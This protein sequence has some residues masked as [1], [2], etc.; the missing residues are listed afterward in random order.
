[1]RR[2]C[3]VFLPW[4]LLVAC[5]EFDTLS[6]GKIAPYNAR[7]ITLAPEKYNQGWEFFRSDTALQLEQARQSDHWQPVSLPHTV[8]IEPRVVNNQWQGDAWYRKTIKADPRWKGKK[9]FL[10]FEGAMNFSEVWLNGVKVAEHLGGYSPFSV[11]IGEDLKHDNNQLYVRLDN[12]DNPLSGPKPLTQLD[13]NMYGGI[14]RN[15]WLR[16][17]NPLHI[18]HPVAAN[19][20]ASGGVF[21]RFSNVIEK[22]ADMQI[23][24]HIA[25]EKNTFVEIKIVQQLWRNGN[26][27]VVDEWIGEPGKSD[28]EVEQ[29]LRVDSPELWSPTAP[30]LYDLQTRL[31]AGNVLMDEEIQR[32]GIR[33]F[34]LSDG[35]LYINGKK[36]FLRGVNRHQEYP[37]TG[38]ALSDAAQYRDAEK[39]KAAGF[40]YVRLSH[41]PH[42]NAFM[43]AADE[44]GLVLL[45]AILG[46]QYVNPDPAFADHVVQTCRD[47]IR[48]DRNHPSVLAWECS[49]NESAMPPELIQRLHN[50]VHEEY[51]GK[52]TY[53]AGWTKEGY[54]I[55]LQARQHRL[56]HYEQPT[57]P[58]IVSEYGDWEYFAMNAGLN[59]DSWENLLPEE[60]SSRQLLN[61]GE[62]RLQQQAA[63]IIEAHND[64]FNTPAFA[65]GYWVMFDYNRGYADDIEA[66]G[67]MSLE[68]LPKFSYHL[69]QT[70]RDHDKYAGPLAGGYSVFIASHWQPDSSLTVPVFSNAE[71]VELLL[72][73]E[74]V[75]RAKPDS[76]Y[77]NLAHPPF[78]FNLEQFVPGEL[79]ARAY[80]GG[81]VVAEYCVVTPGKP[82]NLRLIRE[83]SSLAP[84]AGVNDLMFVYAMLVDNAG[85]NSRVNGAEVEFDVTGDAQLVSDKVIFTEDGI[86]AALV[87]FGRD[88]NSVRIHARAGEIQAEPLR[89]NK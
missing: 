16:V 29:S 33:E 18:T 26:L 53:S 28:M 73:D 64:N 13:F 66:S 31:Y 89:L 81:K 27:I 67:I 43:N 5:G 42:A 70:Q 83:P 48:R 1:M 37:Y 41:Y 11:E 54:D 36:T 88:L 56:D 52:N 40:D 60:R 39:I 15:V 6:T 46:W 14:Y 34:K 7:Q 21:A 58:Y 63:N 32:I 87:R 86:A 82:T 71:E 35:A 61:A 84:Q 47:L 24:T 44:L 4:F 51:P 68:R 10:D 55:Y 75:A 59:Q 45:D 65:D 78:T 2:S 57:K 69:F 77:A 17:E 30:N 79:L 76:R 80:A 9:V 22:H 72:N 49:L 62:K 38:Y 3:F 74:L 25:L 23:N 12:R 8:N 85:N 50:A 19:K 20:V